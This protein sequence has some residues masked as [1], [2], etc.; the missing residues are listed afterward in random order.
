MI[1]FQARFPALTGNGLGVGICSLMIYMVHQHMPDYAAIVIF[2]N[3]AI[4]F[5]MVVVIAGVSSYVAVRRVL[6]IEPFAIFRGM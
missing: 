5:G 6:R 4:A 1:L 2:R 3:L